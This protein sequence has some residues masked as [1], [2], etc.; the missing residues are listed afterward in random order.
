MAGS[1]QLVKTTTTTSGSDAV[2]LT[3]C[4]VENFK[5]YKVVFDF[6]DDSG[7][8]NNT[9][10]RLADSSNSVISSGSLYDY[11]VRGIG[12]NGTN[13]DLKNTGQN[14]LFLSYLP[15]KNHSLGKERNQVAYVYNPYDS[16]SYT[17]T[18]HQTNGVS[19]G[20]DFIAHKGIGV[21]K[22]AATH[23]GIQL[24]HYSGSSTGIKSGATLSVYGVK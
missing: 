1:L 21:L 24:I 8:A 9:F 2:T 11:A 18:M 23:K 16:S 15:D 20:N 5:V 14:E 10:F 22:E 19:T 3:D 6:V 4:F 13:Y 17:F 12:A 7:V